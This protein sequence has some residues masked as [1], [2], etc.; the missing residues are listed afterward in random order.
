MDNVLQTC[1]IWR[2]LSALGGFAG[3]LFRSSVLVQTLVRWWQA[4]G[5]RRVLVNTLGRDAYW[6]ENSRCRV[7]A[8]RC[9][10]QLAGIHRPLKWFRCS[11]I[12][13]A[14]SALFRWGCSSHMLGWL[15]RKG[16]AGFV[17]LALS[18]YCGVDFLLRD[19]LSIAAL[20]SVWDEG[21]LLISFLW[22]LRLRM[23]R[24][25]PLE[26]RMNPLDLPIL[27]FMVLGFWLMNTVFDY[28]SS[29]RFVAV[30]SCNFCK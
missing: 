23:D 6:A 14:Y 18:L 9:N 21:L 2:V 7:I 11:W 24:E 10:E 12:G 5:F 25:T 26:S 20:A 22:I 29:D 19:V 4:C 30:I 8:D 17:L 28:Y 3:R 16:F 13:T 27:C 15:F 1:L